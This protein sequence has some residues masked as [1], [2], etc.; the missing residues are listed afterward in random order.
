MKT[1]RVLSR[2]GIIMAGDS[3]PIFAGCED[4]EI[5]R[6]STPLVEFDPFTL[7]GVTASGRPYRLVG[8]PEPSHALS[9]FHSLWDAGDR[10]V[11]VVSPAEA[12]VIVRKKG[13]KPFTFDEAERLR[14][15]KMKITFLS[16]QVVRQMWMHDLNEEQAADRSG[17]SLAKLQAL[18]EHDPSRISADEADSAYVRLVGTASGWKGGMKP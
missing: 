9:V 8:E 3:G 15:E 17:L 1:E 6:T 10:I 11:R 12:S 14:L 16:G 4:L 5:R 13:N 18:L 2:W 7:Q